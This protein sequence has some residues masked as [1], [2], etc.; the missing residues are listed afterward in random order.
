MKK[1]IYYIMGVS[2]SGKSTVGELLSEQLRIP[3]FDGDDFHPECNVKKMQSGQSLQDEDRWGWLEKINQH[4]IKQS[5]GVGAIIACSALK[6][7][8]RN[9]LEQGIENLTQWVYLK[10]DFEL[11]NSRMQARKEHYMPSSLL[12]SQFDTL[13][14]P[15]N[16]LVIDIANEPGIIVRKIV[17]NTKMKAEFGLIGLGVMGKSLSRNL[18]QKGFKLSV[19]N[20]HVDDVEVNVAKNFVAEYDELSNSEG[21][22]HLEQFVQSLE[23]PRKIMLMVNAGAAVDAVIEALIPHLSKGDILI[24][25]G[26]SHYK[27]TQRRVDSLTIDGFHFIGSGVSG[28]EEGALKGPSIMPG[29]DKESYSKISKFLETIAA[30]PVRDNTTVIIDHD[31]NVCF[32]VIPKY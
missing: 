6:P 23:T 15:N 14:E 16:A 7:I 1:N 17:E 25:G 3:Y 31:L 10:G 11:I 2:G 13:V 20:R 26:N 9:I 19:Y 18:A 27:D 12:V 30:K 5:S 28:G 24:D 22:D 8:Y 32:S 29:G 4:A 21:Y